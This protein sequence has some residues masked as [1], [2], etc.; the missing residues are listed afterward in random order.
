MRDTCMMFGSFDHTVIV[1][2]NNMENRYAE[3]KFSIQ[4][5]EQSNID[6]AGLIRPIE[7]EKYRFI[8]FKDND[9]IKKLFT[10]QSFSYIPDRIS[11]TVPKD[12]QTLQNAIDFIIRMNPEILVIKGQAG[13]NGD[14]FVFGR[15]TQE[16]IIFK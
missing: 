12:E 8:T 6:L 1:N 9:Y 7:D 16:F 5:V 2:A 15:I 14:D 13:L 10:V 11:F 4:M 3:Q